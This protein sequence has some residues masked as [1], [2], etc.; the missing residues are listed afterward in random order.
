[1]ALKLIRQDFPSSDEAVRRFRREVAAS[2]RL[3]HPNV[4][5]A[6]NAGND[7]CTH[8][9]LLDFAEGTDL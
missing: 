1:V 7:N 5:H 8:Y 9:L 6:I 3:D 4:A 2:S